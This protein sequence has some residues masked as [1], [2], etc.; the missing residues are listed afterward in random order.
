M[1]TQVF[2]RLSGIRTA[3]AVTK[4]PARNQE[5]KN[6]ASRAEPTIQLRRVPTRSARRPSGTENTN[7][8]A[9]DRVSIRP[10]WAGLSPTTWVKYT[11]SPVMKAPSANAERTDW[12]DIARIRRSSG[13]RRDSREGMRRLLWFD[14]GQSSPRNS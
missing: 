5:A 9:R 1:R 12:Y 6:T 14:Q 8:A 13:R 3:S 2:A 11:A 10:T 4:E 7:A